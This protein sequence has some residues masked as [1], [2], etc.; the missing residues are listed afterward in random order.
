MLSVLFFLLFSF[1]ARRENFLRRNHIRRV[2]KRCSHS[3]FSPRDIILV[4]FFYQD[5][6]LCCWVTIAA[7][8]SQAMMRSENN[9]NS[10]FLPFC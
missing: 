7:S 9:L 2:W 4:F 8:L 10:G 6:D 1:L 5:V 3:R